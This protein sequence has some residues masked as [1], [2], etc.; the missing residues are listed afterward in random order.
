MNASDDET[1]QQ[2]KDSMEFE[3]TCSNEDADIHDALSLHLTCALFRAVGMQLLA[4]HVHPALFK[5]SLFHS[6]D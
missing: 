3:S 2:A 1:Y 6:I 4:E 5:G